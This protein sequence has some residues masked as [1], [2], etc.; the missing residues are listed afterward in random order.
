MVSGIGWLCCPT[1]PHLRRPH[2]TFGLLRAL[3]V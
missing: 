3:T 2:P 1:L